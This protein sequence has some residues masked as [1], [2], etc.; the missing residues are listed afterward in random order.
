MTLENLLMDRFDRLAEGPRAALEAA[1][2]IG[3]RFSAELVGSTAGLDGEAL[4][5]PNELLGFTAGPIDLRKTVILAPDNRPIGPVHS[6]ISSRLGF[7]AHALR[8]P[9]Q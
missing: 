6:L 7:A 9:R 4:G 3:P 2:V 1:S 8:L 5:I